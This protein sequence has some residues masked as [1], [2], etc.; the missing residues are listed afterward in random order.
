MLWC[1]DN[2]LPRAQAGNHLYGLGFTQI[3]KLATPPHPHLIRNA[4][5]LFD[6]AQQCLEGSTAQHR[7]VLPYR[8]GKA[9][10]QGIGG[11]AMADGNLGNI[12]HR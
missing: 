7:P 8:F 4:D 5:E 9:D 12:G 10:K 11:D 6:A 1:S 3:P 2:P